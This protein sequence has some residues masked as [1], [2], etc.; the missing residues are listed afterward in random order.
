MKFKPRDP[1]QYRWLAKALDERRIP[2]AGRTQHRIRI[3]AQ[4]IELPATAPIG[5]IAKELQTF[6][7]GRRDSVANLNERK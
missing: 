2:L 6:Q 4:L 5:L 1:A 7:P 3:L